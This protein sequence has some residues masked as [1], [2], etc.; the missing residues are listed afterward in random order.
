MNIKTILTILT[1]VVL[2]LFVTAC[3]IE[4]EDEG[5]Y[6]GSIQDA[7][8]EVQDLKDSAREQSQ[9]QDRTDND[10]TRTGD[11]NSTPICGWASIEYQLSAQDNVE[12]K[13]V[14]YRSYEDE[15]KVTFYS[16]S[17]EKIT[18][19]DG[20]I[21]LLINDVRVYTGYEK[22]EYSIDLDDDSTTE[23][24]IPYSDNS[25]SAVFEYGIKFGTID[26]ET[27]EYTIG[28][29]PGYTGE[30]A[31]VPLVQTTTNTW[32]DG[33]IDSETRETSTHMNSLSIGGGNEIECETINDR[34]LQMTAS[35]R[36]SETENGTLGGSYT[37][38][39]TTYTDENNFDHSYVH[40]NWVFHP[41]GT[42]IDYEEIG[43][44]PGNLLSMIE[45]FGSITKTTALEEW[46]LENGMC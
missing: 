15:N 13:N 21:Q 24:D 33:T 43:M 20:Q 31:S 9:S 3:D 26:E 18:Y 4:I 37:D 42:S 25:I 16:I 19:T 12:E 28:F 45:N 17:G 23:V 32:T 40:I 29:S 36:Y 39:D 8:D 1:I 46:Y 14:H 38:S 30:T 11:Y 22:N 2:F 34:I 5:R 7:L 10:P 27:G 35:C 41:L 6:N 44:D